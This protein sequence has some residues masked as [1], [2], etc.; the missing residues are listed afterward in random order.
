V[1]TI[2]N[3]KLLDMDEHLRDER[4][5]QLSRLIEACKVLELVLD[6]ASSDVC[7]YV[8]NTSGESLY[9]G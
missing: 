9:I 1:A 5:R 2:D 6:A 4:T 3:L 7:L 8:E